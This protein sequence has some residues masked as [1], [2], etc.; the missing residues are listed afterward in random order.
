MSLSNIDKSGEKLNYLFS[1]Y[2]VYNYSLGWELKKEQEFIKFVIL[3][4]ALSL[5]QHGFILT[6]LSIDELKSYYGSRWSDQN[7][8]KDL[9]CNLSYAS[10]SDIEII[11]ESINLVDD[12]SFSLEGYDPMN[13]SWWRNNLESIVGSDSITLDDQYDEDFWKDLEYSFDKIVH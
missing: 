4:N 8:D 9:I 6:S 13:V 3:S 2:S 10:V 7:I 12:C 5:N 11:A 1:I